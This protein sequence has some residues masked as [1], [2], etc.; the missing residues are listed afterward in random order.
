MES[1]K[2]S[3]IVA[4][5]NHEKYIAKALDSIIMQKVNFNYE[6]WVGEDCSTDK[7]ADI[8][9]SYMS[10]VGENFHFIFRDKNTYK[11]PELYPNGNFGDLKLRAKGKYMIILEGDDYW[12]DEYKLQKQVDFLE[13]NPTYAGIA[14]N[15][16]IVDANDAVMVGKTYPSISSGDYNIKLIISNILPGQTATFM[17]KNPIIAFNKN[18][19]LL[20]FIINPKYG[21][22]DRRNVFFVS[23][24]GKIYV[25]Q[26]NMSCY[27]LVT[28][29]GSSF[30][31]TNKKE[32]DKEYLHYKSYLDFCTINDINDDY[33]RYAEIIL[34]FFLIKS[35]FRRNINLRDFRKKRKNIKHKFYCFFLFIIFLI[36]KKIF[37]K[38]V[39]Y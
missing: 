37:K 4:T 29:G 16:T 39:A 26:E 20:D 8:I 23:R 35:L 21:I 17:Y 28:H 9:K 14:H 22:G 10:K 19:K 24:M 25:S 2:L 18:E 32:F 34:Y 6:V 38:Q 31:A 13:N 7:T 1:L 27:R 12:T 3:I 5:Y 33:L 30:S 15:C 11:N 36:K